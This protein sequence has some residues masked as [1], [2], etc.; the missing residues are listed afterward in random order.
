MSICGYDAQ[1]GAQDEVAHGRLAA[2]RQRMH[3]AREQV[4]REHL[5]Q[6]GEQLVAAGALDLARHRCESSKYCTTLRK[7]RAR[8]VAS[9]GG[10]E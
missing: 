4:L 8:T 9:S 10:D 7:S 5:L 1:H 3:A 6:Q 2:A